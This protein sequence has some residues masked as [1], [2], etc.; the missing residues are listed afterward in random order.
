MT[1]SLWGLDHPDLTAL[2]RNQ[3]GKGEYH[4]KGLFK[5][6]YQK[7]RLKALGES[8]YFQSNPDLAEGIIEDFILPYPR[9][10]E[11]KEEEGTAKALLE[12]TPGDRAESVYIPMDSHGTLCLSTQ[13][14]CARGCTFCRTAKMG[15]VRNLT[16]GEIVSQAMF[17]VLIR[18]RRVR[19][20]V[21]MGMG[22]PLDNFDN[23]I[24]A[25]DILSHPWGIFI[26]KRFISL[27][28][29]GQVEGIRRLARLSREK[30]EKQYQAL[31]VAVSLN[32]VTNGERSRLMPVNRIWPLEEL[33]D[34]LGDLPQSRTKDRLYYEYVLMKG[35]NDSP[36]HVKGLVALLEGLG[37]KVNLIP[38]HGEGEDRKRVPSQ[39]DLD[40]FWRM[41]REEG[42]ECRTRRSKGEGILAAC[43]Q[44]ATR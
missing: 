15:L 36:G 6:I 44:L 37:G 14:G 43:G 22:E 42:R 5:E 39:E 9:C 32:G 2:L 26:K 24:K 19:N 27:S 12:F 31:R 11:E 1:T 33:M 13:I 34:A 10:L 18:K 21:F 25:I 8:A 20:I 7:G 28:T 16:A 23:L 38:L 4:A 35:V 40:R 3:Y 29:C 41:V 30:P 17:H